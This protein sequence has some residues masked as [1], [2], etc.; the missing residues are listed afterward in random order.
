M[1][2]LTRLPAECSADDMLE[3]S[4][5]EGGVIVEGWL[6]ADVLDRFNAQLDPLLEAHTG[7]DSGSEASDDFLGHETRRLQGL[8]VKAPE[9][10]EIMTD[11]R[12]IEY[13]LG[14]VGSISLS[15]IHI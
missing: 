12:L 5:R 6:S 9:F 4:E 10:V 15:L 8:A 14:V 2:E 7:T 1:P 3:V 13:A 11:D